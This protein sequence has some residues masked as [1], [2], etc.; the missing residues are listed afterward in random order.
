MKIAQVFFRFLK[1]VLFGFIL[2][3]VLSVLVGITFYEEGKEWL[4]EELHSYIRDSQSGDLV[5]GEVELALFQNLPDITILLTEVA[6]YE[7]KAA[8]RTNQDKSILNAQEFYLSFEPWELIKNKKLLLTTLEINDGT[9][10]LKV[11]KDHSV[12]LENALKPSAAVQKGKPSKKTHS[13]AGPPK[14]TPS[15]EIREK[16]SKPSPARPVKPKNNS[17][18]EVGLEEL[19]L[20]NISLHYSNDSSEEYLDL[21]FRDFEGAFYWNKI[22]MGTSFTS[23]FEINENSFVP[24]IDTLGPF[25]IEVET[26]Y[27]EADKKLLMEQ[28]SLYMNQV[29]MALQ[30]E[31]A[32]DNNR[33]FDVNF[34]LDSEDISLL[35]AFI[36]EDIIKKN[37]VALE[38]AEVIVEGSVK[39]NMVDPW[40]QFDVN[41][42]VKDLNMT[43]PNNL[44]AFEN[45][46]FKGTFLSGEKE[47]LSQAIIRVDNLNGRVPG[48][49]IKGS[50]LAENLVSPTIKSNLDI[51]IDLKGYDDILNISQIDSLQGRFKMKSKLNGRLDFKDI[52]NLGQIGTLEVALEDCGFY[53]VPVKKSFA[54]GNSSI[55]VSERN[56]SLNKFEW[57]YNQSNISVSGY[58]QNLMPF[59]FKDDEGLTGDLSLTSG[60]LY[61]V[62]LIP[63]AGFTPTIKDRLHDVQIQ[64]GIKASSTDGLLRKLPQLSLDFK[65][66][67][68]ELDSLPGIKQL[69]STI[70]LTPAENGFQVHVTSLEAA[71]PIGSITGEANVLF[72]DRAKI[73]DVKS[74]LQMDDLPLEYVLDLI[75]VLSENDLIDSKELSL[76]NATLLN[77]DLGVDGRIYTLPFSIENMLIVNKQFHLKDKKDAQYELKNSLLSIVDFHLL[78]NA[79]NYDE[80]FGIDKIDLTL[81]VDN[82]NTPTLLEVPLE[83]KLN[84]DK[85]N[86]LARFTTTENTTNKDFGELTLDTGTNPSTFVLD[87]VLQDISIEQALQSYT[88]E[89][90]MEGMMDVSLHFNGSVDTFQESLKNLEGKVSIASDSLVLHGFDLDDLLKK[91]KRSQNF[92]LVDLGAFALAGPLGAVVTKG[93]DFTSLISASLNPGVQTMVPKVKADWS[94]KQGILRTDDVAFSTLTN[95][96]AFD[97]SIDIDNNYIPGFTVHVVDRKGCSLMEQSVQGKMDSLELSKLNIT[98]TLLGSVINFMDAIVGKDCKV[99]YD[100]QV[101]HPR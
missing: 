36:Q 76:A 14:T 78:R 3:I 15:K 31:Y 4:L 33:T 26:Q 61:T 7:K 56:I 17:L 54:E 77:G 2:L 50:F 96:V 83:L 30:G 37:K 73:L 80:V 40:P 62:D 59:L 47:D 38:K 99:V 97:G 23:N 65:D 88:K 6:Y 45:F 13:K 85:D 55:S 60:Q 58:I 53:L 28:G 67:R 51:E 91:Y 35:A 75:Y 48:G 29:V 92:N 16:T 10:D 87:Y 64:M 89:K 22:G 27:I 86:F 43:A 94:Y 32:H 81:N 44:G 98:K 9:I 68:F 34:N 41:F 5:V 101:S 69:V 52:S 79:K 57:N 100:G 46:G 39:G 8:L 42:L 71:L 82:I 1:K 24:A 72:T 70:N 21:Y 63:V 19:L 66:L 93:G 11:Y 74:E 95:R 25:T 90:L 12:N 18:V 20:K 49:F 84:G